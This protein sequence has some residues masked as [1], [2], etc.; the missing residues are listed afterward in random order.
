MRESFNIKKLNSVL[1]CLIDTI[2]REIFYDSLLSNC[3]LFF[4]KFNGFEKFKIK[5]FTKPLEFNKIY[6]ETHKKSDKCSIINFYS[7]SSSMSCFF[8]DSSHESPN[9]SFK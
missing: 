7:F 2:K 6:L 5:I 8:G 1:S 4:K 3:N 9:E